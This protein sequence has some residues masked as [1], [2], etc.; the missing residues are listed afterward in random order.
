MVDLRAAL[1]SKTEM[2]EE[3]GVS[4]E[5]IA[6]WLAEL[7]PGLSPVEAVRRL[8]ARAKALKK[9]GKSEAD[10]DEEG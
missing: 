9:G 7:P 1:K 3:L 10:A 5:T 2:A 4:R 6:R 8:T